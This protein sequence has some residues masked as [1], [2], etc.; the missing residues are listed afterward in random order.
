MLGLMA[1]SKMFEITHSAQLSERQISDVLHRLAPGVRIPNFCSAE[2]ISKVHD[3]LFQHPDRGSLGHA[4][5]FTRLGMAYSEIRSQEVRQA[6]HQAARANMQRLRDL[7]KPYASPMDELRLVLDESWP[8][9]AHLLDIEGEKCF[10]GICRYQD[11]DV[12][13]CPHI[14]KLEW[15]VPTSL[16]TRL[17]SQL[18]AIIYLQVPEEGG[19]LEIWN[20][21]PTEEEYRSLVGERHYGIDRDRLPAADFT[22]SPEVGDLILINTRLIHAVRPVRNEPR[23]TLSCFIGYRG[24]DSPLIYWS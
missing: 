17:Q 7:F 24:D 10:S 12:D 4:K 23:I 20:I 22:L 16:Q 15:N 3:G 6:Y 2:R 11:P 9:G 5:E 13:L 8:Y 19:E 14:D 18:S 1:R 21:E